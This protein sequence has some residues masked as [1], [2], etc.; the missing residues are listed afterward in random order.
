MAHSKAISFLSIKERALA[1][2]DDLKGK[3]DKN[4]HSNNLS[5]IQGLPASLHLPYIKLSEEDEGAEEDAKIFT[6]VCF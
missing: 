3:A 5:L 4:F 1:T 2:C 6:V